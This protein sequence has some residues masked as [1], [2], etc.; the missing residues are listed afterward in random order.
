MAGAIWW[1]RPRVVAAWEVHDLAAAA[2]DYA[3]CMV[4]PTGPSLLRDNPPEFRRLVRRRLLGS[5]ADDAPFAECAE[6][7]RRLTESSA[8]EK[9][10]R[11]T[12]WNFVEYGGGAA[13]RAA[14]GDQGH[15]GRELGL[16][17]L[18][19]SIK[20]VA[21]LAKKAWPIV[22]GGYTRLVKPSIRAREA[23]HPVQPPKAALGSG[24]PKWRAV[25]RAVHRDGRRHLLAVGR[26]ANLALYESPDGGLRWK[27]ASPRSVG[28]SEFSERCPAGDSRSFTFG[29]SDD[30]ARV[31]V[32]SLGPDGVPDPVPLVPASQNVFSAS[33]DDAALVVLTKGDKSADVQLHLCP[34]RRP[35][36]DMPLPRFP[37]AGVAPR[38]PLD[39][40]RI[41]GTTIVAV[42][43]HGIVRVTSTRDDGRAWVPW[44]V[45]YD[46]EAHIDLPAGLAPPSLLLPLGD[47]VLLYAGSDSAKKRYPVLAS[48]DLGASWRGR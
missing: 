23:T 32:A 22:R 30:G 21:A 29:L 31:M 34:Y 4:G 28:H 19:V 26:A 15:G 45:A 48:T 39:V 13:D 16:R 20:P 10:H 11:V 46:P 47:R 42:T 37:G 7:A 24:L 41:D 12:A 36:V 40:A 25:Y 43:M 14:K 35:C 5:Q 17:A 27:M 44:T 38:F 2:A 8:T 3:L 6:L 33:C 9:A 18:H 1:A